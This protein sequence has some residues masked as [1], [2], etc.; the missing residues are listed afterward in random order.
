MN[1]NIQKT[2]LL[3]LFALVLAVSVS[4]VGAQVYRV[5][6]EDG[7]VTFTDQSPGDGAQPMELRPISVIEAPTFETKPKDGEEGAEGGEE[8]KEMSLR[9]LRKNYQ[10]FAIVA[11]QQEE[12]VWNPESVITVAWNARYA[13]QDGMTVTVYLNGVRQATTTEQIIAVNGP[14]R[15]EHTVTAELKDAKNRKIA[16]AE[17]V[18]FFVRR[19]NLY[20]RPGPSPRGGG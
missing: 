18:T 8:N 20:S 11:P 2:F 9:Y 15:G 1:L 14:D 10:D 6:D 4:T 13:L 19:P 17:P 7:N 16:T 3:I 5:V 12:S